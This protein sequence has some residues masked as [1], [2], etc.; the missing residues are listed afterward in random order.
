MATAR[1]QST[2]G[3]TRPQF[4]LCDSD[5]ANAKLPRVWF[6]SQSYAVLDPLAKNLAGCCSKVSVS[7]SW[8]GVAVVKENWS[9]FQ[10][11]VSHIYSEEWFKVFGRCD[12]VLGRSSKLKKMWM[13]PRSCK[14]SKISLNGEMKGLLLLLLFT[15]FATL[16]QQLVNAKFN[17]NNS[18]AEREYLVFSKECSVLSLK[19]TII[20]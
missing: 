1:P 9:C 18:S 10:W 16:D 14:L 20:I 19:P 4:Q 8:L 7:S 13:R 6:W 3:A 11:E 2:A 5:K 15:L 17:G 12:L